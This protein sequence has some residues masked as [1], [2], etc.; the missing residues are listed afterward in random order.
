ML[1][2]I[3]KCRRLVIRPNDREPNDVIYS[4]SK[5]RLEGASSETKVIKLFFLIGI[6]NSTE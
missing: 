2:R 1:E 6:D 3:S 4:F 5:S